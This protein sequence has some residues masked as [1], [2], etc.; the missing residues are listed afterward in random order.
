ME[1]PPGQKV[2]FP[3][4][5]Y[6]HTRHVVWVQKGSLSLTEGGV[7]HELKAGDS[8]GFGPPSEVIYANDGAGP[9]AYTVILVRT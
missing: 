9:C 3:A 4:W 6:A 5:S 2:K 7:R 8:L 1:L